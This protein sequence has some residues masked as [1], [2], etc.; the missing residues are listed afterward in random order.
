MESAC[1]GNLIFKLW[2][3]IVRMDVSPTAKGDWTRSGLLLWHC[4]KTTRE[5]VKTNE[6]YKNCGFEFRVD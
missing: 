5:K 6:S 4:V 1:K 3:Q 2:S